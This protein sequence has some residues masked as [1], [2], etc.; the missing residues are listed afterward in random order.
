MSQPSDSETHKSTDLKS[1]LTPDSSSEFATLGR[2]GAAHGIKG[3]VKLISFTGPAENILNYRHFFLSHK[4]IPGSRTA[5]G[6]SEQKREKIEIDE[7]RAQ[8]KHFIGHIKGCDDRERAAVYS[9]RELQ[10]ETSTLP[11]L[12]AEDYYWFQLEG[13]TIINLQGDNLGQVDRLIETGANDVIV[14]RATEDSI[15]KEERLIPFVRDKVVKRVDLAGRTLQ[16][17]WEKDY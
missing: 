16:V 1:E 8:G 7:S 2:I 3:W 10:V 12:D 6:S 4:S 11:E 9:G 17:D 13:L 14:V 5:L 15:D